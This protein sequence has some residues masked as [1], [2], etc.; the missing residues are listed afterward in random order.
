MHRARLAPTG[1]ALLSTLLLLLPASLQSDSRK[2]CMDKARADD[3]TC[4]NNSDQIAIAPMVNRANS[5]C[6]AC[7]APFFSDDPNTL[8]GCYKAA[9]NLC[10]DNS[11]CINTEFPKCRAKFGDQCTTITLNDTHVTL[12]GQGTV[13][14]DALRSAANDIATLQ[15]AGYQQCDSK[16]NVDEGNCPDA[17]KCGTNADCYGPPFDPG[18]YCFNLAYVDCTAAGFKCPDGQHCDTFSKLCVSGGD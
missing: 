14:G 15:A 7:T 3:A 18:P 11:D 13:C 6:S 9:S 12:P 5:A 1:L 16:E 2:T 10:G 4:R 8:G 17:G